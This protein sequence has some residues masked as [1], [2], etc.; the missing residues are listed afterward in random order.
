MMEKMKTYFETLERL[1]TEELD[2]SIEKLVRAEKRNVALVI[3]HIAEMSR[4][5]GHVERGYKSLWDYCTRRLRLS[6]G[7][8]ARRI[9]VANV[10]RR[11]P[12]LLVALAE[13]QMSLTVAGLLAPVLTE[14]NVEK[15]LADCV[16]KPS[17]EVEE[18]VVALR[19]KPVFTPSIRKAPSRSVAAS[20]P[21]MREMPALEA[22]APRPLPRVSPSILEPARPET[23]NFRFAADRQFKEKFERL[24]EVFGV[25]NPLQHMAEI[26]KQA[27]DIALDKRDVKRKLA[28]RLA[29]KS[30]SND[31]SRQKPRAREVLAK[32][33]YIPSHSRERVHKRAGYQCEYRAKDGTRCRSRTGL[34]IEHLRPFALYRN[35]DERFLRLFCQPHNR[36]NVEKVFGAAFIQEKIDAARQRSSANGHPDSS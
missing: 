12:Q 29:R 15:L 3:A 31:N 7:S 30:R 2:H 36:L 11:F 4:R 24:A 13:N 27:M 10:C 23:F 6:E 32:S 9:Q 35:H 1:S 8:V 21:V 5:K 20:P 16:G 17:R 26:M 28:R 33:R 25:E 14:S 18:Y 34:Q 22:T 19:P